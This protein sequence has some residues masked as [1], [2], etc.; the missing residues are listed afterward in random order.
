MEPAN[1]GEIMSVAGELN[2]GQLSTPTPTPDGSV[3]VYVEKRLPIDEEKFKADKTR[4]V[5]SLTE[6]QKQVL[7]TEWI[8]VRRDAAGLEMNQPSSS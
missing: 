7:F 2:E 5:E 1:S 6:F 8:K 3:I 4:V